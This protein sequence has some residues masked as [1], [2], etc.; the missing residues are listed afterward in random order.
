[1]IQP[2][3]SPSYSLGILDAN[4]IDMGRLLALHRCGIRLLEPLVI[5][6]GLGKDCSRVKD[7]PRSALG[8]WVSESSDLQGKRI[9]LWELGTN[10]SGGVFF[11]ETLRQVGG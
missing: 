11:L 8:K 9:N 1:M 7:P 4:S 5:E 3:T 10:G 2:L 6:K